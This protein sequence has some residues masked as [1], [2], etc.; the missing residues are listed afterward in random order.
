MGLG[1]ISPSSMCLRILRRTRRGRCYTGRLF[2]HP[3]Q[4]AGQSSLSHTFP[5][6]LKGYTHISYFIKA[7]SHL[8]AWVLSRDRL[9]PYGLQHARLPCPWDSLGKNTGVDWTVAYQAPLSMGILQARI[10]E[11]IAMPS[12]RG[13]SHPGT[14]PQG[15]LH[16]LHHRRV[17][18]H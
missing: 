17:L 2:P 10:L 9:R 6:L 3:G 7:P 15:L 11:W 1:A 14:E 13:S 12:S 8:C 16:L 4:G 5:N 18:Y